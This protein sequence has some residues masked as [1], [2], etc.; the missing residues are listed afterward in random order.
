MEDKYKRDPNLL[1]FKTEKARDVFP[2]D[3]KPWAKCKLK[4]HT[5][6]AESHLLYKLVKEGGPGNYADVGCLFGGSTSSL[7]HGLEAGNHT[8]TI[9]AVD[10]FGTGP[11][12]DPGSLTA[13][14]GIT[15]YF[16]ETFTKAKVVIC[17]G[18]SIEWANRLDIRF[19]GVFID[20]D[21][22]YESCK[23]D[24]EAWGPKIEKGGFFVFHDTNFLGV[25]KA[26]EEM[27]KNMWAF[28]RQV[29]SIK[30]FR[31]R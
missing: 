28:E 30:L 13:P 8:G 7:G 3:E 27:N 4:R 16:E 22:C 5:S 10:Y 2:K 12:N 18:T 23:K 6:S 14:A 31:R 19:N 15:K 9:Y 25:A 24:I 11:E 29:F 26:L 21:H 1:D 17:A 20:A